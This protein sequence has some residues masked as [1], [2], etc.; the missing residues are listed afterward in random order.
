[1]ENQGKVKRRFIKNFFS[2]SW[3]ILLIILV[4]ALLIRL[5]VIFVYGG[6]SYRGDAALYKDRADNLLEGKVP[7]RDFL[8]PKPP[9]LIL[10]IAFWFFITDSSSLLSIKIL[11]SLFDLIC[12]VIGYFYLKERAPNKLSLLIFLLM[13][14]LNPIIFANSAYYGR[15]YIIPA[16]LL[17]ISLLTLKNGQEIKSAITMGI[18]IMYTYFSALFLPPFLLNMKSKK[19]LVKYM[20]ITITTVLIILSPFIY[21][22]GEKYFDDT[23][24][25]HTEIGARGFSVWKVASEISG[26]TS[27]EYNLPFIIQAI[28]LTII[29]ALFIFSC[30]FSLKKRRMFCLEVF[31]ITFYLTFLLLNKHVLLQYFIIPAVFLPLSI[32]LIKT[33]KKPFIIHMSTFY[34]ANWA[35]FLV[36]RLEYEYFKD[37][38]LFALGVVIIYSSAIIPL[39]FLLFSKELKGQK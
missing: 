3:I 11:F 15:H 9:L 16:T 32:S 33:G 23:V 28:F 5:I 17:M 37:L 25:E 6:E 35:I 21:L 13:I 38:P 31:V 10:T 20:I 7:Y 12:I 39:I 24:F 27:L 8:D 26:D 18:A 22:A 2:S 1:M 30:K 29:T 14:A 4:L 36:Y 19:S 34:M